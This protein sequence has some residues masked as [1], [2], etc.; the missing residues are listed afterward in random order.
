M[1][2]DPYLKLIESNIRKQSAY[3]I[4]L[5]VEDLQQIDPKRLFNDILSIRR[6]A[7]R[8]LI[9]SNYKGKL[10]ILVEL[11]HSETNLSL[12]YEI[13]KGLNEIRSTEEIWETEECTN[14]KKINIALKSGKSDHVR[15]AIKYISSNKLIDFLSQTLKV[16]NDER[17]D[18]D[19]RCYVKV[20]NLNLMGLKGSICSSKV[21]DYLNDADLRV[22][23]KAIKVLM[24]IGSN[25]YLRQLLQFLSHSNEYVSQTAKSAFELVNQDRMADIL[26]NLAY[27]NDLSLKRLFLYSCEKLNFHRS[28]DSVKHLLKDDNRKI[29]DAAQVLI[30]KFDVQHHQKVT[31]PN[32]LDQQKFKEKELISCNN[33]TQLVQSLEL[34]LDPERIVSLLLQIKNFSA[35]EKQK[36]KVFMTFLCHQDDQVRANAIELMAPF[37][38]QGHMDFFIPFLQDSNH[39]IR[40]K[41]IVALGSDDTS[42]VQ[43]QNF[44]RTSLESLVLD[45][46]PAY[47]ITAIECIGILQ[48]IDYVDLCMQL[49]NCGSSL[50]ESKVKEL[51]NSWSQVDGRIRDSV[52]TWLSSHG[53]F[54]SEKTSVEKE[55]VLDDLLKRIAKTMASE[56]TAGK[57]NLLDYLIDKEED[58]VLVESLLPYLKTEKNSEVLSKLICAI[59]SLGCEDK[60]FHFQSF[61]SSDE[62][63]LVYTTMKCLIAEH[64]FRIIPIVDKL[65]VTSNLNSNIHAEI[66]LLAMPYIVTEKQPQALRA[67]QLLAKGGSKTQ[68]CFAK[69]L[70]YWNPSNPILIREIQNIFLNSSN[71]DCLTK[72]AD[73]LLDSMSGQMLIGKVDFLLKKVIHSESKSCL[74][75]LRLTAQK[76]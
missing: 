44:I 75:K 27:S 47:K 37:I 28:I 41:A 74:E 59:S 49:I 42:S 31:C 57:I 54:E 23:C 65:I 33:F 32:S 52:M 67:M 29:C 68:L 69:G 71:I 17:L 22:V 7:V 46:R 18:S 61:L 63:F 48:N 51:L 30:Q 36:L 2:L 24:M 38:P 73:Y 45:T 72:C 35:D 19:S 1:N 58:F 70:K 39:L 15:K 12:K 25:R 34:E 40:G 56:R 8:D 26:N 62:P 50:V 43:Y 66:M 4:K 76:K 60:Y 3:E 10:R 14:T 21:A 9:E 16:E 11:L 13:R 64:Y 6:N 20:S 55:E 5:T 53:K